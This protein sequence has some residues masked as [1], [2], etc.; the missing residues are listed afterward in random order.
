MYLLQQGK[1]YEHITI[2]GHGAGKNGLATLR[3]NEVTVQAIMVDAFVF[4]YKSA[5]T[6][7]GCVAEFMLDNICGISTE[8]STPADTNTDDTIEFKKEK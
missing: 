4:T 6:K 7:K 8:A 2:Y 1:Q 5:S 3:F